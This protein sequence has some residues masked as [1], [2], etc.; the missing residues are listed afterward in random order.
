MRTAL[1]LGGSRFVEE[2]AT[3]ALRLF[4]PDCFIAVND[5][6][7]R[8]S[9][10][11]HH[12]VTLHPERLAFWLRERAKN[13]HPGHYSVWSNRSVTRSVGGKT[14]KPDKIIM[15]LG[16]SSGL[17]AVAVG[18]HLGLD[19]MVLA[20]VPMDPDAGHV[21]RGRAPWMGT[22]SYRK[23]WVKHHDHIADRVRSMSGWTRDL[24]GAPTPEWLNMETADAA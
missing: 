15:D 20:G 21:V 9:G 1:I 8:W 14:Y 22:R 24:L 7:G 18:I 4:Q 10:E 2:D 23:A 5:M 11:L 3:L 12:A 17:L 13:C 16:G 19:R 6:I